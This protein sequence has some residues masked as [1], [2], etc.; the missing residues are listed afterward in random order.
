MGNADSRQELTRP[1]RSRA[2]RRAT[3]RS[4]AFPRRPLP[5]G[6]RSTARRC[7]RRAPRTSR[8]PRAPHRGRRPGTARSDSRSVR[9]IRAGRRGAR[10]PARRGAHA[11]AGGRGR[12]GAHR[13]GR[14][15]GAGRRRRRGLR[16]GAGPGGRG[17]PAAFRWACVGPGV[18]G[19]CHCPLEHCRVCAAHGRRRRSASSRI[20]RSTGGRPRRTRARHVAAL[21]AEEALADT[22]RA[23]DLAGKE[24]GCGWPLLVKSG[25]P[26]PHRRRNSATSRARCPPD[27]QARWP[28]SLAGARIECGLAAIPDTTARTRGRVEFS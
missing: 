9:R 13:P 14:H 4:C 27:P 6:A 26:R 16:A 2:F 7:R 5:S 22:V 8:S 17:R 20:G 12:R 11:R 10:F 24:P 19:D 15:A 23:E 3:V 25:H 21:T 28:L 1:S 18:P